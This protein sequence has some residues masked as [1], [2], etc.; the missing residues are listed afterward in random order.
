MGK[1]VTARDVA[2]LADVSLAT[3]DRVLNNRGGVTPNKERRVVLAAR[4]MKLDRA[5]DFRAARTLR[6]AVLVQPPSNPFHAALAEAVKAE[7]SGPNPFNVSLSLVHIDAGQPQRTAAAINGI[8]DHTDALMICAPQ[9]ADIA[10]A[11]SRFAG[12]GK[13][14]V[15]LATELGVEVP[16]FY[17]GP[18]NRQAGRVAG[19]LMGRLVGRE[20]GDI[21]L[22]AGLFSMIGHGE[23][24]EGFRAVLA[25]RYP[26][27]RIVAER[28]TQERGDR[29]GT[30]AADALARN[31]NLRGIYNAS[32]GAGA[33]VG[34]LRRSAKQVTP[35]F[36]TH[37]LT[38]D[39]RQFLR[40]GE[41]DAIIDQ[42]PALEIRTAIAVLAAKFGRLDQEPATTVTPVQIYMTE[43]C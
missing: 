12:T 15:A 27:C 38:E 37:E 24:R 40:S 39:R 8:S 21:L 22:L 16:H 31:A 11:L 6:I 30:L 26:N 28:E 5:L 17:V 32:N 33:I 10:A 2:V 7:S 34:V 20:G 1:K 41:I 13:P 14:V 18:D 4:Q 35:V 43:N 3:V 23:R 29:A 9:Q 25:E 36:I 19:D 42:N